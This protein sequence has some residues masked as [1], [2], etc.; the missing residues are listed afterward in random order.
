MSRP[1]LKNRL[2]AD[3]G[4]PGTLRVQY[5]VAKVQNNPSLEL[6][7][8]RGLD[9]VRHDIMT[10]TFGADAAVAGL[11]L[12]RACGRQFFTPGFL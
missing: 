3:P 6:F 10:H 5:R 8:N 1:R 9:V 4:T 7:F 11:R 12:R 2:L